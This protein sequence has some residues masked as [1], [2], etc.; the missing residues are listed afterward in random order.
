LDRA[1][2]TPEGI[3]RASMPVERKEAAGA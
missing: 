2:F 1:D 3:L